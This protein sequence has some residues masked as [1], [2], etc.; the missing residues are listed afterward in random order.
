MVQIIKF[1]CIITSTFLTQVFDGNTEPH[2]VNLVKFSNTLTA[3]W[4]RLSVVTV[5]TAATLRMELYGQPKSIVTLI[6]WSS[7]CQLSPL[8]NPSLCPLAFAEQ[9]SLMANTL[10]FTCTLDYL[11]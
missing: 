4:I 9:G 10:S 11:R 5:V 6:I 2:S 7:I 3:R 1:Y 8:F